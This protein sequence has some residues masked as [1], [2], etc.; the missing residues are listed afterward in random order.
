MESNLFKIII[1]FIILHFVYYC[2]FLTYYYFCIDV[3]FYGFIR[4]FIISHNP[5]CHALMTI[6][7]Q[8]Q[9]NI[10]QLFQNIAIST[11]ITWL[12]NLFKK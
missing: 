6:T 11:G 2:T 4:S 12:Y 9:T 7:Y 1:T 3:S 8:S 10:N 5:I